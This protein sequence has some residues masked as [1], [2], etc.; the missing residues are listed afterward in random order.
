MSKKKSYMDTEN[1][2]SEGIIK[3]TL[4]KLFKVFVAKPALKKDN[5][6]RSNLSDLNSSIEKLEKSLNDRMKATG[7]KDK[8]KLKKYKV[9][10]FV[11]R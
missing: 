6:F 4:E 9:K 5:K 8:I 11:R 2:L 3:T 7:S 1:I 10:D